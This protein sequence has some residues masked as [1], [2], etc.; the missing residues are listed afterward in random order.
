MFSFLSIRQFKVKSTIQSHNELPLKF[1]QSSLNRPLDGVW[2]WKS[3]RWINDTGYHTHHECNQ[4]PI[5]S[6]SKQGWTGCQLI[7]EAWSWTW[8][9][10]ASHFTC[11]LWSLGSLLPSHIFAPSVTLVVCLFPFFR[12]AFFAQSADVQFAVY[13]STRDG[14]IRKH[15]RQIKKKQTWMGFYRFSA[16]DPVSGPVNFCPLSKFG[17]WMFLE[18]TKSE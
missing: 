14:E 15:D 13:S 2:P 3:P 7:R 18:W 11:F 1:I 17:L 5:V 6:E 16:S 12:C 4:G 10:L 9:S 8:P